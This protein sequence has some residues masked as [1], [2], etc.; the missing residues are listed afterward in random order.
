M[1]FGTLVVEV[2]RK[3][4]TLAKNKSV[5]ASAADDEGHPVDG[6]SDSHK[7]FGLLSEQEATALCSRLESTLLR[8]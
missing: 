2:V 7:T 1:D 3:N 4:G 6:W 5:T 8:S